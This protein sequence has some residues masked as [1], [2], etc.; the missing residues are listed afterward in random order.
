MQSQANTN[1]ADVIIIGAGVAGLSAGQELRGRGVERVLILEARDRIGGRIWSQESDIGTVV[2]LGA[3]W[4]HGVRGNPISRLAK[5]HGIATLITDYDDVQAVDIED[6]DVLYRLGEKFENYAYRFD[7]RDIGSLYNQ[8]VDKFQLDERLQRYLRYYLNA[9]YEHESGADIEDLSAQSFDV[10]EEFR[11]NDVIFPG[12]YGQIIEVLARGQDIRLNQ[13]VTSI[14]YRGEGVIVTT[15]DNQQYVAQDIISTLPLGVLQSGS[16]TFTP[17]LPEKKQ[18]A[19]ERLQMG[20]LDKVYIRFAEAFWSERVPQQLFG[21]V[22]QNGLEWSETL[23]VWAYTGEPA[24]LMFNSGRFAKELEA[25]SDAEI[26][27][28]VLSALEHMFGQVPEPEQILITRWHADPWSHGS[29]SYLPAGESES[30][31]A[32][33]AKPVS[34]KLYFAGEASSRNYPATVHGAYLSG[35]RAA[36][37]LANDN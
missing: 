37:E 27:S 2:D 20:L 23:N 15:K 32:E 11:G 21:H 1:T 28:A 35:L 30:E 3:S 18:R 13:A 6:E 22:S 19:I 5:E 33:M 10:G 26:K 29:Y 16:V 8:F 12:G 4:I 24:L 7:E 17:A 25:R 34:K 31:Y 14:D 36:Q 9:Y